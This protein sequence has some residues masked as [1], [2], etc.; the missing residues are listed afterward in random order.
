MSNADAPR[1]IADEGA[2]DQGGAQV[3]PDSQIE[4][5][6]HP[7]LST[8]KSKGATASDSIEGAAS[9]G[10]T[11][12]RRRA[13][14]RH[15][16]KA[17]PSYGAK[18]ISDMRRRFVMLA[19][20]SLAITL[21]VLSVAA[22]G[23]YSLT[24]ASRSDSIIE[25]LY[26]NDGEFPPADTVRKTSMNLTF[27]V[28]PETEFENRYAWAIVNSSGEIELLDADH[29]AAEDSRELHAI[30]N[31]ILSWNVQE[32]YYSFYR[33]HV[34][35][36]D[37]GTRT[38]YLLDCLQRQQ[39]KVVLAQSLTMMSFATLAL[40]FIFLLPLSKRITRSYAR[41]LERQQ[42]FVTDASHELKTP[43][44]IISANNDITE[45]ISGETQ[46]TRSTKTQI[47]RLNTL[48][49]DL[50]ETARS[51][52]ALDIASL[53]VLDLSA[54]V[55]RMVEDFQPLAE[56][57]GHRIA[58]DIE[59]GVRARGNA[60]SLERVL[61]VLLDNAVKH[62]DEDG[63]IAVR[64]YATRRH[65]VLRVGNPAANVTEE[66]TRHLFD[67]FYRTD[68]SRSRSTGGYGIG[69]STARGNIESHG[70]KL[71]ATKQ[72]DLL[73][74]VATLPRANDN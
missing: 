37:D 9:K 56:A 72:G 70:G 60:E 33:F 13:V 5:G 59:E 66:E 62:G 55:D 36:N 3:A 32:G 27:T 8:S 47:A 49:R 22:Y 18:L 64:L 74:F 4:G 20:A 71:T 58:T 67:R 19:M 17:V 34:F 68:K 6:S 28:N 30:I 14:R 21:I 43:L 15:G 35:D 24:S 12:R 11:R 39:T 69:L 53:P 45:R 16:E 2:S 31:E 42:R 51:S 61:S 40:V 65:A 46:W 7:S 23:Y 41:N 57:K 48:T 29:I 52:E 50:I 73:L 63:E 25:M 54:L 10:T 38:V 44:T 26:E 1:N